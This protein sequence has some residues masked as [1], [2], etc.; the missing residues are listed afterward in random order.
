MNLLQRASTGEDELYIRQFLADLDECANALF[1]R[2]AAEV[3]DV[4]L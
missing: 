2:E 4:I 1:F 3:E